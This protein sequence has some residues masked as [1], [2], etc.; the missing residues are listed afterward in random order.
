M[1]QFTTVTH[2][3]FDMDGLLLGILIFKFQ[4]IYNS[5]SQYYSPNFRIIIYI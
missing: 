3:I 2:V 4:Y 1:D 5:Q